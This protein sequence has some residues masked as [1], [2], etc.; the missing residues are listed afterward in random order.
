MTT[1]PD[2]FLHQV[3]TL[4]TQIRFAGFANSKG[5][6]F[7][8]RYREGLKPLLSPEET[9]RSMLQVVLR[10]GMRSTLEDKIGECVYVLGLYKKVKRVT[11]PLRPPVVKEQGILMV[12]LD[13]DSDHDTILAGKVLPFL[14]K[15]RLQF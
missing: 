1:E 15:T 5:T 14:Q 9:D 12:S 8:H 13:L 4:D 6:K 11:I 7:Y 2:D 10:S 3:L